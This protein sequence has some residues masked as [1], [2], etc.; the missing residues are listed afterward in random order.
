MFPC[1]VMDGLSSKEFVV[2]W[3]A[4]AEEKECVV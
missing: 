3:L 1:Q 2:I 4:L